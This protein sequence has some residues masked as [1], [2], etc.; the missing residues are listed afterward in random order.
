MNDG[1]TP[2]TRPD[3]TRGYAIL[4]NHEQVVIQWSSST[5]KWYFVDTIPD[6]TIQPA[7]PYSSPSRSHTYPT[8]ILFSSSTIIPTSIPGTNAANVRTLPPL[9]RVTTPSYSLS[10]RMVL[11]IGL[12]DMR[13]NRTGSPR[14][15]SAANMYYANV[16]PIVPLAFRDDLSG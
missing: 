4:A 10:A 11:D 12:P 13:V 5:R 16:G 3:R 9:M 2:D 8:N 15:S 6:V 14:V 7:T 1:Y